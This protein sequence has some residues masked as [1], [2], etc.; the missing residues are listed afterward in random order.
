MNRDIGKS[1]IFTF[2]ILHI[3]INYLHFYFKSH[4]I[5]YRLL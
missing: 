4:V 3:Y 1:A 2:D 5:T